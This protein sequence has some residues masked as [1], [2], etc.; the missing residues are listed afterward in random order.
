[1][2]PEST[3]LVKLRIMVSV[4][5]FLVATATFQVVQQGRKSGDIGDTQDARIDLSKYQVPENR[6]ESIGQILSLSK[7]LWPLLWNKKKVFLGK[8]VPSKRHTNIAR[9]FNCGSVNIVSPS[10]H[11]DM[12]TSGSISRFQDTVFGVLG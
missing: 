12:E 3:N 2:Q 10:P 7:M 4:V 1:M 5:N 9:C 8:K 11:V 6:V